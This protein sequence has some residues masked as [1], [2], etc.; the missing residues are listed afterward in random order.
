MKMIIQV[1]LFI[2]YYRGAIKVHIGGV[3][4]RR[5]RGEI[6][7]WYSDLFPTVHTW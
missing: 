5:W 3:M 7:R 4:S 1:F 6:K 2:I